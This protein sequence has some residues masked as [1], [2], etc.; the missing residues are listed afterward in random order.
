MDAGF[1]RRTGQAQR[2]GATRPEL[3]K[4]E[5]RELVQT[6]GN[7]CFFTR[8]SAEDLGALVEAGGRFAVPANWPLM[9]EQTPA[10]TCYAITEGTARVFVDRVQIAE[11]GPGD[12]VGEMAVLTGELRRATV[13]S[14]TRLRGL[15]IANEDLTALFERRPQLLT[16]LRGAYE[17]RTPA[18]HR[19]RIREVLRAGGFG[20]AP[21]FAT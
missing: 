11:L 18:A 2:T 16:V 6:L 21:N 10:D 13:T 15:R 17:A 1:A 9:L 3:S 4:Q 5:K 7:H 19:Q 12:I 14:N 20:F 8:C